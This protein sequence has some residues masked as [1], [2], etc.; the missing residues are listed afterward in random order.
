MDAARAVT[1]PLIVP[2]GLASDDRRGTAHFL[3]SCWRHGFVPE[4]LSYGQSWQGYG[5]KVAGLWQ[6][7]RDL[8]ANAYVFYADPWDSVVTKPLSFLFEQFLTFEHDWV[9]GVERHPYPPH[10]PP[11]PS[12][13]PWRYLNGGGWFGR[14]GYIDDTLT[15]WGAERVDWNLCDQTFYAEKLVEEPDALR[16]DFE[17]ELFQCLLQSDADFEYIPGVGI[18]NRFTGTYPCVLHG[19]GLTDMTQLYETLGL[20]GVRGPGRAY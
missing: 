12:P 17:C 9:F 3:E 15:R 16:L 4:L 13:T 11:F 19:N 8:P 6:L 7:V 2:I 5:W 1:T 20:T 14:A 10:L 18:L